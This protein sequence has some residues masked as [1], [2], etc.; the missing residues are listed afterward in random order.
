MFTRLQGFAS[1]IKNFIQRNGDTSKDVKR[2]IKTSRKNTG[3]VKKSSSGK[4]TTKREYGKAKIFRNP[5][6]KINGY[7]KGQL[8]EAYDSIFRGTVIKPKEAAKAVL[9]SCGLNQRDTT[10]TNQVDK[11]T[12]FKKLLKQRKNHYKSAYTRTDVKNA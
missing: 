8:K 12:M 11:E 1:H 7:S 4:S 5:Y 3:T 9:W 2:S 10:K 6:F